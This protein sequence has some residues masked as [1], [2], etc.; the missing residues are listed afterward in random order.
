MV[1]TRLMKA[2]V[3]VTSNHVP[4][5]DSRSMMVSSA[6]ELPQGARGAPG[7]TGIP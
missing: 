4:L 2:C 6:R 7:E 1:C 5:L 3:H